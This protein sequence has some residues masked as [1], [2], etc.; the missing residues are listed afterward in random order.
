MSTP[1]FTATPAPTHDPNLPRAEPLPAAESRGQCAIRQAGRRL[2]TWVFSL[3][4]LLVVVVALIAADTRAV[5]L[6]WVVG[7]TRASLI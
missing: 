4:A 1:E 6:D 7:S 5:K 3:V 2:F